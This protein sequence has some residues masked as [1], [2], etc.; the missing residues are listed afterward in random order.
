MA[1]GAL[2]A[3][4]DMGMMQGTGVVWL[5]KGKLCAGWGYWRG[6]GFWGLLRLRGGIVYRLPH[7]D[8]RRVRIAGYGGVLGY[9][10]RLVGRWGGW[11]GNGSMLEALAAGP[12]PKMNGDTMAPGCELRF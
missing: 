9:G 5:G 12:V 1:H 8:P 10:G 11:V 3:H 4:A 2:A 7:R 6:Y